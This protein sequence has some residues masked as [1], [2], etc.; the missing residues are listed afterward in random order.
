M[1]ITAFSSSRPEAHYSTLTVNPDADFE[2]RWTAWQARGFAHE[3]AV[4]HRLMIVAIAVGTIATA[5]A[6]VYSLLF[7]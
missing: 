5:V 7:S 3:R 1:S 2:R 4:K 6:I